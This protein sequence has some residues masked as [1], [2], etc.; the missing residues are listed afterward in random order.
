MKLH[1][2]VQNII[3][4]KIADYRLHKLIDNVLRKK[5]IS[6]GEKLTVFSFIMPLDNIKMDQKCLLSLIIF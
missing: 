3:L 5:V 6:K 4:T 1:N 2:I